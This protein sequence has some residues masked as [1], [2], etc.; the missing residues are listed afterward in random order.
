MKINELVEFVGNGKNKMLKAAQLEELIAKKIEVK[1]Y[2]GIKDKKSLIDLIINEC[3][4]FEDG[5]FKFDE[6]DKY[7][8]FT[9]R[10]IEA[11]T[12]LELSGDIEEDYDVLCRAG[13][14]EMVIDTFKKEYEEVNILLQMK[15]DYILS[16]NNLSAQ[17]GKFLSGLSDKIDDL[18]SILANKVSG[19]NFD[20]LNINAEDIKKLLEIIN[21]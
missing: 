13:L 1:S 17:I 9:M 2:L 19:F 11:Y 16:E 3:I 7:I 5:I 12:N 14:L 6:I 21:K 8:C 15:S 20:K 18:S 10:V 4:L